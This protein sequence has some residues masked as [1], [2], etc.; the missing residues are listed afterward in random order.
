MPKDQIEIPPDF[1]EASKAEIAELNRMSQNA[2]LLNKTIA[3]GTAIIALDDP[4][5]AADLP[6]IVEGMASID[7]FARGEM[8]QEIGLFTIQPGFNKLPPKERQFWEGLGEALNDPDAW[9][10]SWLKQHRKHRDLEPDCSK[11]VV[12]WCGKKHCGVG[13]DHS[14]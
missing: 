9:Y 5:V 12:C 10:N 2:A 3:F 1:S 14:R 11:A 4:L 7:P 13:I 6:E 8:S